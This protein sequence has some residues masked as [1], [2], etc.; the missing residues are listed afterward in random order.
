MA[1]LVCIALAVP[2][3]LGPRLDR[4]R[5]LVHPDKRHMGAHITLTAP[6]RL[7]DVDALVTRVATVCGD[8]APVHIGIG[9]AATF[10]GRARTVFLEVTT[11]H[12]AVTGIQRSVAGAAGSDDARPFHP[13][14]TLANRCPAVVLA[15][16]ARAFDDFT[17]EFDVA[18]V[19]VYEHG[20][21][22]WLPLAVA[23]LSAGRMGGS[24]S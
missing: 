22:G 16:T 17:A 20:A 8:L 2:A 14:V 1:R 10:G 4:A 12:E 18:A 19:T 23:P 11:G 7:D 9:P 6:A 5:M 21:D 15:A 13:H 3:P 24:R